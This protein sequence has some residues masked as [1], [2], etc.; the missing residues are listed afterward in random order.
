MSMSM[1][2]ENE[3]ERGNP[4][5]G[6]GIAAAEWLIFGLTSGETFFG[7]RISKVISCVDADRH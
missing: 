7:V 4:Y 6:M 3:S 1:G 2:G 5:G